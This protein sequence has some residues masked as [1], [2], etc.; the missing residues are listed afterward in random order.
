MRPLLA[1]GSAAND[2]FAFT[3][4]DSKIVD[5]DANQALRDIDDT[6]CS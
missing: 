1:V 2:G 5:A 6:T 3:A 4:A